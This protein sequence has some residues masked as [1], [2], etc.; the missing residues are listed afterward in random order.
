MTQSPT[1]MAPAQQSSRTEQRFRMSYEEYC[2]WTDED[3]HSE[4]VNG[5]VTVFKPPLV[6]HQRLTRLLAELLSWYASELN[7]GEVFFAPLE[8]CSTPNVRYREPDLMFVRTEHQDWITAER[9]SQPADLVIEIVSQ[10]SASRDYQKKRLEY[11]ESG[12]E[13]YWIIDPRDQKKQVTF[14]QRTPQGVY[15]QAHPDADGRYYSLVVPGFWIQVAWL[16]QE[17]LPSA[18]KVF[19][20]IVPHLVY[21][22][23]A[24]QAAEVRGQQQG[25]EAGREAERRAIAYQMLKDG[26][27]PA[28]ISKYTGLTAEAIATLERET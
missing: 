8:M 12:V 17:P 27:D 14:Y 1:D 21:D 28:M 7:L 19:A 6:I 24:V 3:T 25:R 23:T 10:T 20:E 26:F 18:R 9:L 16:W 22:A 5:E 15:I 13:E 2:A 11:E 4:W